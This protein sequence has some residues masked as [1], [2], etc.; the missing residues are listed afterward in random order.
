MQDC[1]ASPWA[2]ALTIV[3]PTARLAAGDLDHRLELQIRELT[4]VLAA[5]H[6]AV[7]RA[8]RAGTLSPEDVA[9]DRG[10]IRSVRA[11]L[12]AAWREWFHRSVL[13]R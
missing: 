2:L 9:G 8:Q 4:A 12:A 1:V 3:P 5:F 7:E 6:G 10:R 11:T 13:V